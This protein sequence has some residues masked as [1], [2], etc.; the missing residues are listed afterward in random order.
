MD[1]ECQ[2]SR[3][4]NAITLALG[5]FPPN[6]ILL[7]FNTLNATPVS[8]GMTVAPRSTFYY[9]MHITLKYHLQ[10]IFYGI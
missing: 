1:C 10:E 6:R 2:V 9:A 5:C 8:R 4:F 3:V 7:W